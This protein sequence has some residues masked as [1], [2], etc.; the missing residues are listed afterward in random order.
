MLIACSL[1]DN[2][3]FSDTS[4]ALQKSF[5]N[6]LVRGRGHAGGA[7]RLYNVRPGEKL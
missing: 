3:L 4:T 6:S 5:R 2:F 7:R 1:V